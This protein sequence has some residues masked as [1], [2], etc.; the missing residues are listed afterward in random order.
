MTSSATVVIDPTR[1]PDT[2]T[3]SSSQTQ[4]KPFTHLIIHN[5]S[6]RN[7]VRSLL[8]TAAA[9]G[10]K[11]VFLVG[12][13]KFN[14]D[15]NGPDIPLQVKECIATGGLTILRMKKWRELAVYLKENNIR[16]IG[17]E[18]HKDSKTIDAYLDHVETAYLLGNEGQGL[19]E[20][21]IKACNGFVRIPQYGNGT[22]S[23]NVYVAAS[24][25]LQRVYEHKRNHLLSIS[26]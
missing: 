11:T 10:C 22:A 18:I 17:V 15:P 5:I 25:I 6:K 9:F 12:Q 2:L 1:L 7:N 4:T 20:T 8:L 19:G 21:Q 14:V 24:I 26:A 13:P 3:T 23:L 16:L